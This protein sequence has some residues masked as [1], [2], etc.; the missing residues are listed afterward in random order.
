M[1][2]ESNGTHFIIAGIFDWYLNLTLN[3]TSEP[4][5]LNPEH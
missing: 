1:M 4:Y 2:G 5:T 3:P